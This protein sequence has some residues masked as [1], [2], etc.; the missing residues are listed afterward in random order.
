M[1]MPIIS[2]KVI[3][4]S[5]LPTNE[6]TENIQTHIYILSARHL[7]LHIYEKK[8]DNVILK[9]NTKCYIAGCINFARNENEFVPKW[10]HF[11][12]YTYI[13]VPLITQRRLVNKY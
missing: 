7:H 1:F 2:R 8:A 11:I 12:L 4:V 9:A 5:H 3:A 10:S 6:L 13:R